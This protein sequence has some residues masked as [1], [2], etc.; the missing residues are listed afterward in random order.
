[1]A[2]GMT[3]YHLIATHHASF[4]GGIQSSL[5]QH[6]NSQTGPCVAPTPL[7][8]V[9]VMLIICQIILTWLSWNL[10]SMILRESLAVVL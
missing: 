2:R 8:L 9:F 1:M 4:T 6:P 10:T 3:Q 5:T 7:T